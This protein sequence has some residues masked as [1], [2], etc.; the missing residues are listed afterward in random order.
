MVVRSGYLEPG[1]TEPLGNHR[2]VVYVE[3]H[4]EPGRDSD[5]F[6]LEVRD[7]DGQRIA[8][9]SLPTPAEDE[10]VVLGGGNI[11]APYGDQDRTDWIAE[12]STHQSLATMD[13]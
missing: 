7:K 10:A 6:W 13:A 5:R 12:P 2:F 3:D 11:V 1:W 8:A 9:S 4:G